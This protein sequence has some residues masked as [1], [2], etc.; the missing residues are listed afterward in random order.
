MPALFSPEL[1]SKI[2]KMVSYDPETGEFTWL[3]HSITQRGGTLAGTRAGTPDSRKGDK[4]YVNICLDGFTYRAHI[5]A[6]WL[7]MER[8]IPKGYEIDHKDR[9]RRNNRW[10]NLR[11]CT[12]TKNHLNKHKQKNNKSGVRGIS[13]ARDAKKWRVF[14]T[15]DR[16]THNLGS[17]E[18]F[19][20]AVKARRAGELKYIGEL[21]SDRD[22]GAA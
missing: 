17:F 12:R 11:I 6:Y 4:L 14:L 22:M 7:M 19:E 18:S 16:V 15:V 3:E 20:D 1:L 10:K 9:N 2:K 13:R 5:L 21:V 8:P